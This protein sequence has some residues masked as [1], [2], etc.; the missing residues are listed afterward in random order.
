[1]DTEP[2][3]FVGIDWAS[4]EHQV[5]LMGAGEP[6][7]RAFAH[8]AAGIGAMV[9]WLCG[10]AKQ[11]GQVAVAIETPHGP[12]VEALMDRGI[13]VFAINPKQLDR[14]R[15]RFSPAGAKDDRR[16]ALVLASSLRTDRH[17]FRRVDALDPAVVELREW[18]RMA[19]EL[20]GE[21]VRLANR[22]RQQLWRYYPQALDLTDDLGADWV[23]ALWAKAPTPADARRLTEKKV[24][25]V[26]AAHRIRRITA[27]DALA[28]LQR[29]ALTV[30]PG[31]AEAARAHITA[32]AERLYLVNRQIK[33]VTR[34]LDALVEQL[35]GPEPEPGQAA[36]QRDATILR[37]LPGVGR[38]V[39]ATL[40]AEAHQAIQARD[41]HALRTL[42]GVAPVTKR[43]GKSRRVEMRQACSNRLRTAVYHWARVATQHDV[44]SRSRYAAL[45][46]RGHS[47][48]RA[49]R[50]VADRL[51]GI[52]C[53]M[54]T[55]RTTYEP[56]HEATRAPKTT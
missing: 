55:N 8:D 48:G 3:V 56:T 54:L 37:S 19:E 53:I 24:A 31:T 36:E 28:I 21:R 44:R 13:A 14:F 34:R 10:Q 30:A 1:M 38:I 6:I 35:A 18:S 5:C 15:D 4:T 52:A 49:L 32:T 22:V 50:T 20:K 2:L 33:D 42:A 11:S 23:L 41:Y 26:L 29:P 25:R 46:A 51:L 27:A 12:V 16:D 43:S 39:L 40:L 7:Q 45:R 17:C 9:D 47:H